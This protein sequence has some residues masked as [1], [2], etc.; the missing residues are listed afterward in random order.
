M[1]NQNTN[2]PKV[3]I[4]Y[5]WDSKDHK[6]KVLSFAERLRN[7]GINSIIDHLYEFG[8]NEGWSV[9]MKDKIH[10]TDF[11]LMVCTENYYKR[12]WRQEEPGRGLGV[13]WEAQIIRQSFYED[14]GN[15]Q[16]IICV[17]FCQENLNYIPEVFRDYN[18]YILNSDESYELL[19]RHLFNKPSIILSPPG[20]PPELPPQP[21]KP[22]T[23]DE[24]TSPISESQDDIEPL[25]EKARFLQLKEDKYQ[26]AKEAL[27][28]LPLIIQRARQLEMETLDSFLKILQ[29][30]AEQRHSIQEALENNTTVSIQ[31]LKTLEILAKV[32]GIEGTKIQSAIEKEREPQRGKKVVGREVI[33]LIVQFLHLEEEKFELAYKN[34]KPKILSFDDKKR[35][36]S[37]DLEIQ[38]ED[39]VNIFF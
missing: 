25:I 27:E 14:Q 1:S 12:F 13:T 37:N 11:I 21:I 31:N 22:L 36:L 19:L 32:I 30:R 6:D 24:T 2:H 38:D 5:S 8:P 20:L 17:V 26:E 7:D 18:N 3:F 16:N 28:K 9:W 29:L 4:S 10:Q 15:N 35:I 34:A 23:F 39:Y 33:K